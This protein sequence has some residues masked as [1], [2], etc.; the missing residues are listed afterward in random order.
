M[1]VSHSLTCTKQLVRHLTHLHDSIGGLAVE[2]H[3]PG[4]SVCDAETDRDVCPRSVPCPARGLGGGARATSGRTVVTTA[5]DAARKRPLRLS[6]CG[7]AVRGASAARGTRRGGQ[8]SSPTEVS[9]APPGSLSVGVSLSCLHRLVYLQQEPSPTLTLCGC[10][11]ESTGAA[12]G[13]APFRSVAVYC[14]FVR[15][16]A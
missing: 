5:P 13:S 7:G 3:R 12:D 11:S 4:I 1:C 16:T 2:K 6:T 15:L 10:S 9:R 14:F 8:R